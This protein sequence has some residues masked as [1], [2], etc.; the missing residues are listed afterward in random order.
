MAQW[1]YDQQTNSYTLNLKN[2][3]LVVT[4]DPTLLMAVYE[5][6]D[7]TVTETAGY[8][9]G[10][11]KR[12]SE[13]SELTEK[14]KLEIICLRTEVAKLSKLRNKFFENRYLKKEEKN[15]VKAITMGL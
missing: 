8:K 1:K 11:I 4:K 3:V 15:L 6:G 7:L 10:S 2:V 9:D 12:I 5:D 14:N 13:I